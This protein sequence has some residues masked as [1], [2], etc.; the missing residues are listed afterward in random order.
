MVMIGEKHDNPLHHEKQALLMRHLREAGAKGRLVMEMAEQ[1]HQANLDK[2]NL[3]ELDQL[4]TDIAWENRG[5]PAWS[6]YRPIV[7]EG[8]KAGM[9]LKA[10]NSRSRHPDATWARG[11]HWMQIISPICAGIGTIPPL[12]L[13]VCL[14]SW[15]MPIAA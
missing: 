9:K 14:M 5:W 12:N 11:K 1:A 15:S 7:A 6:Q 8:L 2:A 13:I 3:E 10:G 4:G